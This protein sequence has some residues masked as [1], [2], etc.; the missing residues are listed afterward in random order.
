MI[1][2]LADIIN[3]ILQSAMF[4]LI[5]NY[6]IRDEYKQKK[7]KLICMII[8]VWISLQ[9]LMKIMGNSSMSIIITHIVPLLIILIFYKKD[10][11]GVTITY[12]ILYLICGVVVLISSNI[13]FGY[14]Q[15][16]I[17]ES[18][19]EIGMVVFIYSIQYILALF[20]FTNKEKLYKTYRSIRSRNFSVIFLVILTLI[21][22]FTVSFDKIV[23][24]NDNP[25]F[26]NYIFFLLALFLVL[27]TIYFASVEKKMREITRLNNALEEKL[28]ELN[29]VKHDYGAQISYLYGLHLMKNYE[30]AGILLKD[31]INGNNNIA[32][33]IEISNHSDSIISIVTKGIVH[34]GI[35]VILDE[36]ADLND[37]EM[38]EFELQKVVSN[39][40]NNS[41]TAINGKGLLTIRTYENFNNIVIKIQNDGPM[42][43]S[44]IKER[45]FEAKFSTKDNTNGDH[46]FGLAIVKEIVEAYKGS[47]SVKS[48]ID[49]TEFTIIIPKKN[50]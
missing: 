34:N 23:N 29:K 14:I 44:S 39:I 45:I 1:L 21:M 19:L 31:I 9:I 13:F 28:E 38:T 27:A 46:G 47:I 30:R 22:D 50:Q 33:A 42:I 36:H 26:K 32:D 2:N 10:K 12:S 15:P 49:K 25:I 6:C 5:P 24:W 40:V 4:V 17:P 35:N 8:G 48:D 20:I 18:Y 37:I 11:L 7:R 3:S 43:E 16:R 41:V